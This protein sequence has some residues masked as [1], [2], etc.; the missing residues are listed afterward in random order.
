MS[1]NPRESGRVT[2]AHLRHGLPHHYEP[3]VKGMLDVDAQMLAPISTGCNI[4]L[5]IF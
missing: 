2:L 3:S 4:L 5:I 1:L